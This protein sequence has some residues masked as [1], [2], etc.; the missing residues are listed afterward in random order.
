VGTEA[1]GAAWTKAIPGSTSGAAHVFGG[2][3]EQ[4]SKITKDEI[5]RRIG[6]EERRTWVVGP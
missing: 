4:K 5:R 1:R 3:K 2:E 6:P